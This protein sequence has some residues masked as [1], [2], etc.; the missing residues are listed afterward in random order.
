M[1]RNI[2]FFFL[3]AK[4]IWPLCHIFG[5]L[6]RVL[7]FAGYIPFFSVIRRTRTLM[8]S[9]FMSSEMYGQLP[10]GDNIATGLVRIFITIFIIKHPFS[11]VFSLLH[12]CDKNAFSNIF[13]FLYLTDFIKKLPMLLTNKNS[14]KVQSRAQ[15]STLN[16]KL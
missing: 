15:W 11:F 10:T 3:R 12:R 5:V 16:I 9:S 1:K 7:S 4:I 14:C 8:V 2:F 13:G 6:W